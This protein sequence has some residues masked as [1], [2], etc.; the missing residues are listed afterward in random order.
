[1]RRA[2]LSLVLASTLACQ[3]APADADAGPDDAGSADAGPTDTGQPDAGTTDAGGGD[4]GEPDAGTTDAGAATDLVITFRGTTASFDRAQHGLEGDGGLYVE[5]HFGGDPA[6]PGP[7]SP[8]P[9]RTLIIAGLRWPGDGGAQ[10]YADGVRV[11]LLDFRGNLSP[12][13]FDRA[14]AVR[15]VPRLVV[16]GVQV[17]FTLDATFDGG[18][19]RG[20]FDAPHCASLDGP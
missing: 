7:S 11:T 17:S 19:V 20:A 15:A 6:C 5:A 14:V 12:N 4:A 3:P 2:L 1:M 13:P 16:P 8:T 10:T 18:V 9:D